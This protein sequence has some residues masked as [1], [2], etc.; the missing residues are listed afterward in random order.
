MHRNRKAR[1]IPP[2]SVICRSSRLCAALGEKKPLADNF[3]EQWVWRW[4][5]E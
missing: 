2:V 5:D 3:F 1:N 4:L